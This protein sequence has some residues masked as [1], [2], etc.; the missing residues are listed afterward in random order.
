M[1]WNCHKEE[2]ALTP[3]GLG[4]EGNG[5]IC[6]TAYLSFDHSI[7]QQ[8]ISNFVGFGGGKQWEREREFNGVRRKWYIRA[9][10]A[11]DPNWGK[12]PLGELEV[13]PAQ[14]KQL[15]LVLGP[16]SPGR[17]KGN[18]RL[19]FSP[20]LMTSAHGKPNFFYRWHVNYTRQR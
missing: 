18:F 13:A 12:G 19:G 11:Q 15:G 10:P 7:L 20:S 6:Q 4:F 5:F 8:S 14:E 2:V 9:G 3:S 17:A 1:S 16:T